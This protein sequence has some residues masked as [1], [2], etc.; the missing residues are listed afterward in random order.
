MA[1]MTQS[2]RKKKRTF[3]EWARSRDGQKI[4]VMVA[5][6]I[7]P[8]LLLFTFTYLPF[9]LTSKCK[10]GPVDQP[11]EPA[12]IINSPFFTVCPSLCNY[13]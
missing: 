4:F 11:V 8:L 1:A 2:V 6:M 3:G 12:F 7:V 13:F 9:N 5:F 10:C